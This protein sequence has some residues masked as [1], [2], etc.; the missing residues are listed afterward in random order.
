MARRI[1]FAVLAMI[2]C[3]TVA[4]SA[5]AP[6]KE[7]VAEQQRQ[8]C[9]SNEQKI[10]TAM[11]LEHADSGFYPDVNAVAKALGV[12]CPSGGTYIFDPNTDTVSCTVHG[13]P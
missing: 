2:L 4:L 5:C 3:T 10:K 13:H 1:M 12:K 9:F 8:E 7:K 6:S 11:D